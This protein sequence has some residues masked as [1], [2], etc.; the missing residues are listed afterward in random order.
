MRLLPADRRDAIF[1]V[2]ALARR[3]DDVADG[4]LTP[5]EKLAELAQVRAELENLDDSGDPV[6]AAVADAARRYPIPLG[7]FGDL[8][9]GAEMDARGTEY[10]TFAD[11]S[12]YCRRVAGRS[13]ASRSAC[14]T[15][16]RSEADRLADELG[17]GLQIGNIL[18]DLSEGRSVGRV[19][20][21]ADDLE[22]FGCESRRRIEGRRICSS[23]FE[24]ERGGLRRPRS[25][26]CLCSTAA[27]LRRDGGAYRGCWAIARTRSPSRA[28]VLRTWEKG[29][30][31]PA[32]ARAATRLHRLV[33]VVARSRLPPD[34][35][36]AMPGAVRPVI[37]STFSA[38]V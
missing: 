8:V 25:G 23:P 37:R 16:D 9:D 26:S 36:K 10:A 4:P 5:N 13:A 24:A 35:S 17:V 19:Y 14:S 15:S 33:D 38:L 1:A 11:S 34:M 3:I 21:P 20:L 7:A 18:R 31:L 30:V 22:R 27:P 2:Y 29:W 32:A 6:L 28:A 12:I